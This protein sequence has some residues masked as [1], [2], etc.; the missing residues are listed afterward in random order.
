MGVVCFR[1]IAPDETI[2]SRLV[3]RINAAGETYLMQTKLRGRPVMRLGLGNLLTTEEH[4]RNVWR[5]I[6]AA[7]DDALKDS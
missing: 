6:Q 1:V 2:N 3:E 5:I 4:L 7:A